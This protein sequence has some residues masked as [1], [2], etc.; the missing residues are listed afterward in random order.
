MIEDETVGRD[1]VL[2]YMQNEA[3]FQQQQ[4]QLSVNPKVG[5]NSPNDEKGTPGT[6]STP[7]VEESNTQ[8]KLP[9]GAPHDATQGIKASDEV[10]VNDVT[11]ASP[12][13]ERVAP[14]DSTAAPHVTNVDSM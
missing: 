10:E 13:M 4:A 12:C 5:S 9:E 8:D 1:T 11:K 6:Y 3:L 7:R 14:P 2:L